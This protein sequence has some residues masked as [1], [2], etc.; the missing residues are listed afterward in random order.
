MLA[1]QYCS[2]ARA[3]MAAALSRRVGSWQCFARPRQTWIE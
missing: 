3:F 1:L 2:S